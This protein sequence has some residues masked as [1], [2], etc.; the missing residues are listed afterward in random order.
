MKSQLN[1]LH[2]YAASPS[3]STIL[4]ICVRGAQAKGKELIA[5]VKDKGVI[6]E[7]KKVRDYEMPSHAAT[8]VRDMGMKAGAK[9]VGM[10]CDFIG[11]DLSRMHNEIGKLSAILGAA[12]GGEDMVQHVA[13]Q[14]R[15]RLARAVAFAHGVETPHGVKYFDNLEWI[16]VGQHG[17]HA[18]QEYGAVEREIGKL[19]AILGAGAVITP[20]AIER[21]IGYSKDY[22]SFEF[23]DAL[24]A[25]DTAKAWR[26]ADYFAANPKAAP[27]VLLAT[28]RPS[29]PCRFCRECRRPPWHR[30]TG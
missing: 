24:A 25:R 5:A 4:V 27:I 28:A 19:S 20:E 29:V 23:L 11:A 9:A 10:L 2:R 15:G 17:T 30:Q 16:V 26:I 13:E 8:L 6:F 1:R 14:R 3:P 21:N 12:R 7:A 18:P 22:N